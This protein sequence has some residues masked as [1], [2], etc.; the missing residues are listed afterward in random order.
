MFN[1]VQILMNANGMPVFAV[2]YDVSGKSIEVIVDDNDLCFYDGTQKIG[3][4]KNVDEILLTA[5]TLHNQVGVFSH[6]SELE[7]YPEMITQFAPI[8]DLQTNQASL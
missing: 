3:L 2:P 5:L 6:R 1:E 7:D 4:I 8:H